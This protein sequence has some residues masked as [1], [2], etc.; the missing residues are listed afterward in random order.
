MISIRAFSL[1]VL[2]FFFGFSIS[3]IHAGR[4]MC[5]RYKHGSLNRICAFSFFNSNFFSIFFAFAQVKGR[6]Q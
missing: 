5:Q 3:G 2:K 1:F 4:K 6:S